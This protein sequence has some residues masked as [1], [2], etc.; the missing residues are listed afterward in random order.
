MKR[1]IITTQMQ[2]QL[3]TQKSINEEKIGKLPGK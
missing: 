2:E 1:Q 3:E